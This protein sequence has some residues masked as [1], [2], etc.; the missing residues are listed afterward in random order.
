MGKKNGRYG[1]KVNEET[2]N[3]ISQANKGKLVK[4]KNPMYG[5][6]HTPEAIEKIKKAN[7]ISKPWEYKAVRCIT[8]GLVFESI[9]AA[10]KF[11]NLGKNGA[12]ISEVCKG[13]RKTCGKDP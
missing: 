3:K 1:L 5:K 8:T 11:Y 7:Q 10:I 9:K 4:E 12:H 2:R 6:T 13:K